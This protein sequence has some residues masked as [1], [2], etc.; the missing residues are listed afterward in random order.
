MRFYDL[1]ID[2]KNY[3]KRIMDAGYRCPPDIN[4]VS[5][6]VKGLKT[7]NIWNSIE[8]IWLFRRE[9]NAG[10]GSVLYALKNNLYNGILSDTVWINNG[11]HFNINNASVTM[12]NYKLKPS[13]FSIHVI[14]NTNFAGYTSSISLGHF[15]AGSNYERFFYFPGGNRE[16]LGFRS[17]DNAQL[18]L[19]STNV[20]NNNFKST[21][22][23]LK[24]ATSF[25]GY[26]DTTY[27]AG[28]TNSN[29]NWDRDG[30]T[31]S[32]FRYSA[33]VGSN[34]NPTSSSLIIFNDNIN[35]LYLNYYSLYKSTVGKGLGLA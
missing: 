33:S 8:E 9:Q 18:N 15:I 16:Y 34:L 12:S 14:D 21:L 3:A 7:L 17:L 10:R 13:P 23:S 1:D 11:L 25:E 2:V 4:S 35:P 31:N 30:T 24:S 22:F 20:N 19:G 28:G 26:Y 27:K 6:F 5:D 32:A 29:F